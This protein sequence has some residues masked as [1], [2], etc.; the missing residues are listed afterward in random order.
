M[1]KKVNRYIDFCSDYLIREYDMQLGK[2]G[3]SLL[4]K[5][6]TRYTVVAMI[7]R[8]MSRLLS[9]RFGEEN[10]DVIKLIFEDYVNKKM[11]G[12]E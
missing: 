4:T 1:M 5:W 10:D 8:E 7:R 9:K 12:Y 3:I 11:M 6:D 2:S